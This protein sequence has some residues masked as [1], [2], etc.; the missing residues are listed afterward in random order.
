MMSRSIAPVRVRAEF[1]CQWNAIGRL[2]WIHYGDTPGY[3]FQIVSNAPD[4]FR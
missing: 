2:K 1:A 4:P 3:A